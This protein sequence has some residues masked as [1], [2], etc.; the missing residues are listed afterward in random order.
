M[1]VKLNLNT[2]I[3]RRIIRTRKLKGKL[4]A[5][6]IST[7]YQI[8]FELDSELGYNLI[9]V[10]DTKGVKYIPLVTGLIDNEYH[11]TPQWGNYYIDERLLIKI[12][13]GSNQDIQIILRFD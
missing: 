1:D 9:K 12:N 5:I 7:N 6:I 10:A 4:K 11:L 13:G 3:G 8:D 2:Q